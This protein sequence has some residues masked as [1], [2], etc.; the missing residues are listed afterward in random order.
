MNYRKY[1]EG[2][3]AAATA[4]TQYRPKTGRAGKSTEYVG[5]SVNMKRAKVLGDAIV[6]TLRDCGLDAY[7]DEEY[8]YVY[9]DKEKSD[10]GFFISPQSSYIYLYGGFYG[11]SSGVENIAYTTNSGGSTNASQPFANSGY[12]TE[13]AYRFYVTVK[14]DPQGAFSIGIGTYSSP[15]S[16]STWMTFYRGVDK[17]NDKELWGFIFGS[18]FSNKIYWIYAD[19]IKPIND[20]ISQYESVTALSM[21]DQWVVLMEMYMKYGFIVM[22]NVYI[23]PGFGYT[24]QFYE[25]DGEVYYLY[26]PFLVKCTTPVSTE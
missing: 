18:Q 24:D 17:R 13:S 1:F 10:V 9:L 7:Y 2:T 3:V 12:L 4:T 11:I 26:T 8:G 16:M 5:T 20:S 25:I 23:D 21:M 22:K 19:N 15:A 14:G 6:S